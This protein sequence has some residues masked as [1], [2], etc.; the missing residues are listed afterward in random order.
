MGAQVR[1]TTD[2]SS[3][4]IR[5]ALSI[6]TTLEKRWS[7]F[8]PDSELSRANR[9]GGL[10]V[11]R[12]S[13]ARIIEAALGGRALTRG[14]FDP[15]RGAELAAAGYDGP[16]AEGWGRGTTTPF[17][18]PTREVVVDA[19]AGL[20]EIPSG[21]ALDLGGVAKGWAADLAASVVFDNGADF[22]GVEVGGDIRI[23]S[24]HRAVV[25]IVAPRGETAGP[26]RVGLRD[27]GVAV[28]GPTRRHGPSGEH[29]LIDPFT[30]RPTRRPRV[31][32]VIAASAAGAEMLATAAAI[33]PLDPACE[34]LEQ[35]G[36]TAWLIEAD[37][38]VVALGEPDRFLLDDGWLAEPTRREWAV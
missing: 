4:A 20:L 27:G 10:A 14:W 29:H 1:V 25:E 37:G 33:A 18:H 17:R 24:H 15:T 23:R 31:A 19:D 11:V 21:V 16:L 6:V 9:S 26:M 34:F 8:L 13:T 30:G 38:E 5:A 32:A 12:P 22:V 28:S 35:A 36:A 7:R 3:I 2:A